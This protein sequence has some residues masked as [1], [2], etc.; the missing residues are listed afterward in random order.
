MAIEFV[1]AEYEFLRSPDGKESARV[2]F[3]AGKTRD[4]YFNNGDICKQTA[5]AIE[6]C[7]KWYPNED[8]V[9][10]F[11]N[12]KTHTKRADD[13][14]S[15]LQMPKGPSETLGVEVNNLD[16]NGQLQYE[17]NGKIKKKKIPMA[18]TSLPDGTEQSFYFP[19]G[20]PKAGWFKGMM[21]ILQEWGFEITPKMKAQCRKKFSDCLPGATQCC[22]H[23]A[24]FNEPDFKFSESILEA[25]VQAQGFEVIFLPKF[26]CELNPIEQCW[27]Y[28]KRNYWL[29]P[30]SSKEEDLE[31]N[32]IKCLNE[33]PLITIQR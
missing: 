23:R 26:H 5:I 30:E 2:L 8:H 13:A 28:A 4:G 6:I 11:D 33:I 19:A 21:V 9:F 27:G 24:L 18:N 22:C 31:K 10:V 3:K 1:S 20:H 17:P 16:S 14:Q 7:K 25:E 12:A 32:I 15:A 29:L